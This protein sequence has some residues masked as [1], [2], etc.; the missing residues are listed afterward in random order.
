MMQ[1]IAQ[2]GFCLLL[3]CLSL[4]G[5]AGKTPPPL[6]QHS[7]DELIAG[8]TA[9]KTCLRD[10][11]KFE[12]YPSGEPGEYILKVERPGSVSLQRIEVE[13]DI[14]GGEDQLWFVTGSYQVRSTAQEC[15][16]GR[17]SLAPMR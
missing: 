10:E 9:V 13:E 5:C 11:V 2:A 6:H 3:L 14:L 15:L 7:L 1:R 8:L 4:S 17:K 16:T 12:M